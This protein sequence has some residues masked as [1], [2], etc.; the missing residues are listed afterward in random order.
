MK[1]K[2]AP[3]ARAVA[4][5]GVFSFV[6]NALMLVMPLYM[7]QIY[8]R[9]LPSSSM[10]TL[11]FL[12][13]IAVAALG[14][15]AILEIVRGIYANRLAARLDVS[16][17]RN[18]MVASM[19]SPR[20]S[21]GDIQNL[22][23]LAAVR[24]FIASRLMFSLFDLPF[25]PLFILL[26]W[27]VHPVLFW[28]TSAGAVV[29]AGIAI[30]NQAATQAAARR[31][32]ENGIAAL[33]TAQT[34]VRNAETLRAMGMV[35]NA[36]SA[37]ARQHAPE[38]EAHDDIARI[39]ALF[40]GLSRFLR[41]GLQIAVLG[42]GALLVLK[43]EMTAGM[44]FATSLISGRGLQPID[45]VIGGWRQ[46]MDARTAWR[47]LSGRTVSAGKDRD[48]TDLPAPRGRVEVENVTYFA[49]NSAADAA[50]ILKNVSFRIPAGAVVGVIGPSGAGKSTLARLVVGAISPRAGAVRFDGADIGN[51]DSEVLGQHIGYLPQDVELLPGTIAENIARFAPNFEDAEMVEAAVR[52]QVHDLIQS[53]PQGYDTV[54]GPQGMVLSGGQRQ[55]VGLARAFYGRPNL[56]VLD[57][58]NANLD[59]DGERALE[60]AIDEARVAGATVIIVT[61]RMSIVREV[62]MLL[63][64]RAG[65]IEDYG[66][67]DQVL[68]R[69]KQQ[70]M[71][72]AGKRKLAANANTG[73]AVMQADAPD[74]ARQISPFATFGPGLRPLS[75]QVPDEDEQ[76]RQP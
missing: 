52:A 26:L 40:A 34:F 31:A 65:M 12:T 70:S 75:R 38:L 3:A 7:L 15:L 39:N 25:A 16:H 18:A 59:S 58:P 9:V 47:R 54:I 41:L 56:L 76:T 69:K 60:R 28:M 48:F 5:I 67:R 4:E 27:L 20:A 22:R 37:W 30:A 45:Q 42:V 32:S 44:I 49:P 51:W 29:L 43:G 23:D 74:R 21:L 57:E 53:M 46:Y 72:A 62:D 14:L 13:I 36:V 33:M 61:Q 35:G 6:V 8:D 11:V 19:G 17:S 24:S 50:P 73:K 10:E 1:P 68:A 55:R 64:L 71:D 63:V 66:P 2:F